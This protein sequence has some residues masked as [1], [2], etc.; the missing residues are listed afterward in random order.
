MS[1]QLVP[2]L[3]RMNC[4]GCR[5]GQTIPFT[6]NNEP[7]LFPKRRNLR[8]VFSLIKDFLDSRPSGLV[9]NAINCATRISKKAVVKIRKKG[10][11]KRI[12]GPKN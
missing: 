8:E 2:A 1:S 3:C 5:K 6:R 7:F 9:P 4:L 12:K 11:S 10:L